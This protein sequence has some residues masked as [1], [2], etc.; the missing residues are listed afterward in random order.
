MCVGGGGGERGGRET[1]RRDISLVQA[2]NAG[3]EGALKSSR[4]RGGA[5]GGEQRAN[6]DSEGEGRRAEQSKMVRE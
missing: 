1:K 2:P 4:R 3:V 5:G 6:R